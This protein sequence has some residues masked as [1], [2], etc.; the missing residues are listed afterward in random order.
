MVSDFLSVKYF[1]MSLLF[2]DFPNHV[3]SWAS[4]FL[5]VFSSE[6]FGFENSQEK[7]YISEGR[8]TMK[9]FSWRQ[10]SYLGW[11]KSLYLWH[12][13]AM[14]WKMVQR[15]ICCHHKWIFSFGPFG[16]SGQSGLYEISLKNRHTLHCSIHIEKL[17]KWRILSQPTKIGSGKKNLYFPTGLEDHL[18][19]MFWV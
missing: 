3:T 10:M 6:S 9:K 7:I 2:F 13:G 4:I 1:V 18:E 5:F 11:L 8:Q 17:I 15:Q 14:P 19:D 12:F 16:L